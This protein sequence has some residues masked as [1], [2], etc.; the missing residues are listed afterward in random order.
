MASNTEEASPGSPT[1]GLAEE[2]A[3]EPSTCVAAEEPELP[4][5][6]PPAEP[7]P[8]TARR[9]R[10]VV[11]GSGWGAVSFIKN[12]DPQAFGE[13]GPY[14]LV[15]VSP[16]NYMLYTPLLPSAVG[17]VVSEN[18]IVESIRK[19]VGDKG[20]YYEAR[21]A[22][23]N[24]ATRTLT[25]VKEYCEVCAARKHSGHTEADHTFT[26]A[27]DIVL[28]SVGAVNATFG[29]PGVPEH[30]WFLK[31]MEDASRLRRHISKAVEHAALPDT[32]PEQRKKL[33]SFVVVGG[34]PTGV[35]TAAELYDLLAEDVARSLPQIKASCSADDVSITLVDGMD[36]LLGSFHKEIQTYAGEVFHHHGIK[37]RLGTK[38]TAVHEGHISVQLKDGSLD[39]VPY[40]TAIWAT[41]IA[42]H[43]LVAQLQARLPAAVQTSRRGLL[44]DPHL[45]VLG[46]Q[47]TIFC[48]G[49]AA[50]TGAAPQAALPPTA[51]VAR[52]EGEYLAALLS[53]NRLALREDA[54]VDAD[55]VGEELVP[56]PPRAKPFRYTHLGALAYLG[57]QKGVMDL[58]VKTPFLKTLR[59]Y[60]GA[61]A[62]RTLETFMQISPRTRW[63]VM[64]DWMRASLFGRNVSDI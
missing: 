43:P 12:L 26:L 35:E 6:A 63:L 61:Q 5:A 3:M 64:H 46:S 14:E 31:S 18:S 48:L 55:P 10:V 34:G 4:A 25:C 53:K 54:D 15:V 8:P 38:V 21:V 11:L 36:S 58:P 1:I 47:G 50:V 9:T 59:G 22:D 13:R 29:I 42:M 49:D 44:V 17:G 57:E 2:M 33:L 51:Q 41:G 16:R 56:L 27:Y 7:L 60:L 19:I 24:P 40:G 28:C 30:C 52:Q 39:T 37:L 62:W 20:T 32:T 45:R 23:I